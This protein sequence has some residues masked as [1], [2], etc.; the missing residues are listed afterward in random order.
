V[1]V[2]AGLGDADPTAHADG[3]QGGNPEFL[4]ERAPYLYSVGINADQVQL[5]L[6]EYLTK[7]PAGRPAVHAGDNAFT[8]QERTF[9]LLWIEV[10]GTTADQ[11]ERFDERLGEEG[12]EL[13][14]SI[15][16]TLDP[17]RLQEQAASVIARFQAAG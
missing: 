10:D 7:K 11:A 9:G 4:Q 5:H 1:G 6:V 8:D 13:V 12:I 3:G 17:A 14:E 16:Y 2:V 15:P